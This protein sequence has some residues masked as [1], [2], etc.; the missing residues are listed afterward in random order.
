MEITAVIVL[1]TC[2]I[3]W[4]ALDRKQL[5]TKAKKALARF[6][7]NEI[8]LCDISLWEI[9]LLIQRNRLMLSTTA[10]HFLTL[11]VQSRGY[12]LQAITPAIAELSVMLDKTINND[13]ADRLIVATAIN[14]HAPLITADSNL[15][16]SKI[17]ETIW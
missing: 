2:I 10:S 5:S 15:R 13:P 3:I 9:A 12:H 1:D 6:A 11:Y 17:L 4:D 14:L 7:P 8:I 16:Q